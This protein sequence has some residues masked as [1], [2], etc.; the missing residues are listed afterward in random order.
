[1]QAKR[2][3]IGITSDH[4]MLRN[5]MPA[6]AV[7]DVY[8]RAVA[9]GAAALPWIIPPLGDELD[10]EAVIE[11]LD[12]IVFTGSRSNIQPHHYAGGPAPENNPEDPER[13]RTTLPLVPKV[14]EAGIP[15]LFVCRG[16][17][18]LNVA[19]GGTLH[20]EIHR[21]DGRADHRAPDDVPVDEK[22]APAHEIAIERGGVLSGLCGAA[23]EK[24]NSV[25]GQGIAELAPPLRIEARADDGTIEA[26][27]V[28]GA[29]SFALGVQWH[30]EWDFAQQP[31]YGRIWQA[32]GDAA[33]AYLA[34]R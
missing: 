31:F 21:L 12:G 14:L 26:V 13:D 25:H 33:R 11:R 22:F 4:V 8:S 9:V 17:Q 24:V 1:M 23:R 18:E 29:R 20:Q 6:A 30:P 15:A 5:V 2:P 28:H 19:L 7:Y 3:L 32:F 27:S 10:L 16:M 34:A